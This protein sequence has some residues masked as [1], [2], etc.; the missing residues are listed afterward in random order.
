MPNGLGRSLMP[1][2]RSNLTEQVYAELR[3]AL[4]EGRL[5]P[6]QRL[7]IRD[8]ATALE[9]SETPVREAVLQLVRERGLALQSSRSITVPRLSVDQYLEL[10]RIRF[11]LEGLAAEEAAKKIKRGVIRSLERIH[12]E[13]LHAE[14]TQDWESAVRT[15]WHFHHT[16][17]KSAEMHELLGIIEVLWL[18]IG[19]L[20][21]YQYPHAPPTYEGRHRHL[22]V[23]ARLKK[24][25]GPGVRAAIVADTVEGGAGMLRLL[26]DMDAG[27]VDEEAYRSTIPALSPEASLRLGRIGR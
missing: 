19:P 1:V 5:W 13:L 24:R 23:L 11:E 20:L 18:R 26:K 4:L 22:D 9:V 7:K 17:Y 6:G 10:R 3:S 16:I 27:R 21:N 8:L 14:Q 25:D 2:A 12:A 15:N